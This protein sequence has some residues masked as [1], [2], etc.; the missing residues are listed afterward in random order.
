MEGPNEHE[1]AAVVRDSLKWLFAAVLVASAAGFVV[2]SASHAGDDHDDR[3]REERDGDAESPIQHVVV[4]FQ[5]TRQNGSGFES[6]RF[7]D[8]TR[9]ARGWV[10]GEGR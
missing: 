2:I 8:S 4:V 7:L 6:F 1:N 5:E 10:E 3:G 9:S